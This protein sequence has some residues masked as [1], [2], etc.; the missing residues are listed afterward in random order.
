MAVEHAMFKFG[1][2]K[3]TSH[4]DRMT[5]RM[6]TKVHSSRR[7]RSSAARP[8][9]MDKSLSNWD[10]V[11]KDRPTNHE[12]EKK[13]MSLAYGVKCLETSENNCEARDFLYYCHHVHMCGAL[14]MYFRC[15]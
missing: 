12:Q 13:K 5:D 11:T 15:C 2:L 7:P 9:I 4:D 10:L 1:D 3:V 6:T 14:G 8:I